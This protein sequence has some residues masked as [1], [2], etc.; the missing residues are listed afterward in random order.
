LSEE[1]TMAKS[2][3]ARN[4]LAT[5]FKAF[6]IIIS[7][8]AVVAGCQTTETDKTTKK[9]KEILDSQKAIVHNALDNGDAKLAHCHT[10]SK[11]I[12]DR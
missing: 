2:V 6:T 8:T 7:L 3:G 11:R 10:F 4:S 1:L 5:T 9:T 12:Q